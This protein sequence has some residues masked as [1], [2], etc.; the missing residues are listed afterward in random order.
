MIGAFHDDNSAMQAAVTEVLNN[1]PINDL[2]KS[3]HALVERF[4]YYIE[5]NGTIF[6]HII[7]FNDKIMYILILYPKSLGNFR[8]HLVC[9]SYKIVL[10]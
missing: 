3:V 1:I 9:T 5:S 8:T 6:E 2:Q 7:T 4:Q 10:T